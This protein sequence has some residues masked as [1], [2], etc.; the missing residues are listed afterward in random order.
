MDTEKRCRWLLETDRFGEELNLLMREVQRQGMAVGVA[1][2]VPMGGDATY[3][4]IFNEGDC[5][6]AYGSI[7][8]CRRVQ[9]ESRWVPGAYLD[10][11]RYSC[12]CYYRFLGHLILAQEYAFVPFGELEQKKDFLY[13]WYGE[14]DT[15]FLRPNSPC[16]PFAGQLVY[17]E[18]FDEQ[19]AKMGHW[20]LSQEL[21]VVSQPRNIL[22][23]WRFVVVDKTVVAGSQYREDGRR[24]IDRSWP[25][26]AWELAQR[27]ACREWEPDRA[28]VVDV[29]RTSSGFYVLEINA[30]SCSGFYA[31][32]LRPIVREVSRAAVSQRMGQ[33][34]VRAGSARERV[35]IH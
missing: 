18:K 11:V 15:L 2:Y 25:L 3:L 13:Q 9:A 10:P 19:V 7:E 12:L 21:C 16:K 14:E 34:D 22:G 17:R 4:E 5:V 32:D 24:V 35:L 6:V 27:A 26:E 20:D 23:E 1:S 28:W 30:L 8:F 33:G 31:S 29:C